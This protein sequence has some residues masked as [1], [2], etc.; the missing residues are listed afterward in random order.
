MPSPRV[1]WPVLFLASV[2]VAPFVNSVF[3]FGEELGWRGYL[4][5]KL[6]PLGKF[7]AYVLLGIIWGAWHW[8]LVFVGFMFPDH[9]FAGVLMFTAL[10]TVFGIYMN[11]LTLRHDSTILASWIHGVFNAQRLG[12]WALL[13][14]KVNPWLGGVS[15]MVGIGVWSILALWESRRSTK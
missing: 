7:R 10:T 9:P 14:P 4:L 3:A 11:E 13:F 12:I 2:F 8:P 15:G 5:P 6:L 1:I